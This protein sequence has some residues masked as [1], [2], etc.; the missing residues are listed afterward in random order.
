MKIKLETLPA[1]GFLAGSVWFIHSRIGGYLPLPIFAACFVVLGFW[2]HIFWDFVSGASQRKNQLMEARKAHQ[3]KRVPKPM[4]PS[5]MH[6][7]L[8]GWLPNP[9]ALQVHRFVEAE[10]RKENARLRHL[11][12]TLKAEVKELD[13]DLQS[14][15][16]LMQTRLSAESSGTRERLRGAEAPPPKVREIPVR[17]LNIPFIEN[18]PAPRSEKP[19]RY[20]AQKQEPGPSLVSLVE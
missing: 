2:I 20:Y 14:T 4:E 5:R 18:R 13:Q 11:T 15:T 8:R 19:G 3:S 6:F 10:L 12:E 7:G 9:L 1:I 16:Q 17:G